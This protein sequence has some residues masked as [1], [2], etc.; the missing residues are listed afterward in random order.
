LID[1]ETHQIVQRKGLPAWPSLAERRRMFQHL[2][3]R[4]FPADAIARV[5]GRPHDDD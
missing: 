2:L 3:R 5:R 4:G 1:L